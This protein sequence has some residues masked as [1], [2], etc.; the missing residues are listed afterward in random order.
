MADP[1]GLDQARFLREEQEYLDARAAYER[2]L[3]S[4]A[5]SKPL[6]AGMTAMYGSANQTGPSRAS[7]DPWIRESH[8]DLARAAGR[9]VEEEREYLLLD[10][11]I[12]SHAQ[13]NCSIAGYTA[14]KFYE[15]A[16]LGYE[17]WRLASDA[18][19]REEV[20]SN[21]AKASRD[22][23]SSGGWFSDL[24]VIYANSQNAGQRAIAGAVNEDIAA[25][26]ERLAEAAED[27]SKRTADRIANY[28]SEKWQTFLAEWEACGIAG[29]V[30]KTAVDGVFLLGEIAVGGVVLKGAAAGLRFTYRALSGGRHQVD[31]TPS[32]GG[33]TLGSS[34]RTTN[35][36]DRQFKTPEKNHVG[37]IAPDR[38]QRIGEGDEDE[39]E[40]DKQK[41]DAPSDRSHREKGP[42]ERADGRYTDAQS[43]T[44]AEH[45]IDPSWVEPNGTLTYPTA[46]NGYPDGFVGPITRTDIPA[47]TIIDRI[48]GPTGKYFSYPGTSVDQRAMALSSRYNNTPRVY[49]VVE[50][51]PAQTGKIAPWYGK[52][53]GGQ[54]IFSDLG[55]QEL[56]DE[57]YIVRV[58]QEPFR[59]E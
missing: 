19:H 56:I 15:Y 49:R 6:P 29:A 38:N 30:A 35:E 22:A 9:L 52:S 48:G 47:E 41:E 25:S 26:N 2:V 33:P 54:Q 36:L 7:T 45:D 10:E 16:M 58:D 32:A 55:E 3:A 59:D 8:P 44:A 28:F 18:S 39:R 53:G 13:N 17:L 23:A 4:V 5:A 1:D 37:G 20:L 21:L 42:H 43:E 11:P 31:V 57:G 34:T 50:P 14:E 40:E 46:A 24:M 27:A 12:A 51:F